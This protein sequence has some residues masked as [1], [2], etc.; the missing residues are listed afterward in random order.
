MRNESWLGLGEALFLK[1]LER[2][3]GFEEGALIAGRVAM[4]EGKRRRQ[5]KCED[6]A[7]PYEK[8]K[9]LPEAQQYLKPNMNF[10]QLDQTA[11]K[12]SDTECAR[13]MA[14][15]KVKLL[16]PCKIESPLP[17]TT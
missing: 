11:Q 3:Q 8:L 15:A 14:A 1:F 5:Y 10:V 13:K 17:P 2:F 16:R 9:R 7:T 6:Y 4:Q 12:M